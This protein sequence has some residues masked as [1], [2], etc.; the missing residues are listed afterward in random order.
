MFIFFFSFSCFL[1]A[2]VLFDPIPLWGL[3]LF[4]GGSPLPRVYS[5]ASAA[6]AGDAASSMSHQCQACGSTM[7]SPLLPPTVQLLLGMAMSMLQHVSCW[8]SSFSSAPC[9]RLLPSYL[10]FCIA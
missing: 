6:G 8:C 4:V 9:L 5:P 1:E 2:F 10:D 7:S 3:R